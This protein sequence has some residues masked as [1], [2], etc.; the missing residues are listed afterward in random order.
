MPG[1]LIQID[2]LSKR[3][4]KGALAALDS[5][6]A[7]VNA[8]EVTGLV[9]PDGAGKTTLLR[10]IA[11]LLVP[12]TGKITVNGL[13]PVTDSGAVHRIVSYM[14]QRFGLYEDLSVQENL[15]LYAD[16]RSVLGWLE[17]FPAA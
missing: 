13:D 1:P 15:T 3:F 12:S 8:G 7:H 4:D 9:G 6:T 14:P 17:R 2:Q 11:G 16:L 10:L 5:V